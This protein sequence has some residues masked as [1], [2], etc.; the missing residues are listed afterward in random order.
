[1][2]LLH[3]KYA[4][5]VAKAKSI[6]KAAEVLYISQPNLSR[7]IRELEETLGITIFKRTTKGINPTAQGEEFLGYARQILAQVDN[8]ERL[9]RKEN[10]AAQKFSISV[11]R[12]SYIS[13]A[14]TSFA[15]KIS[16]TEKTELFYRETNSMRAVNNVVDGDYRLGILRYQMTYDR[17]FKDMLGEKGL[18]SELICD[19]SYRLMMSSKNPLSRLKK[20][21]FADLT[22]YLEIAHADPF[23]PSLPASTIQKDELSPGVGRRIF[24]FERGSQMELLSEI[25]DAFMWVSPVP[26]KTLE[27]YGLTERICNE[28]TRVYRD[29]L[30][31]KKDY[32]FTG[33]DN[34]FFD[35]LIKYKR[36]FSS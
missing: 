15:A 23:V 5:E 29:I 11:P 26:K 32:K 20:I 18:R 33:F 31:C 1:M 14:F 19:F 9:Y 16:S 10:T 2:N 7:S 30:I 21:T 35:E 28:N 24:V 25:H 13:S 3:M 22:P 34:M 4:V 6:S 36:A 27:L 8:V 17:Y 12:A